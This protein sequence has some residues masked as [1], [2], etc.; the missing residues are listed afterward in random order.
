MSNAV[1]VEP[2]KRATTPKAWGETT[3]VWRDSYV[4]VHRAR[5]EKGGESSVHYHD[6]RVNLFFV[7]SGEIEVRTFEPSR[8]F[9]LG[10]G[11]RFLVSA[12][13]KHQFHAIK[14]SI[15]YEVY[16]PVMHDDIV[17]L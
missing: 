7:E 17:R 12:R 9:L 4:E 15:V 6:H 1:R 16:W 2:T 10:P 5:I 13:M 3:E 8:T 11:S 14:D